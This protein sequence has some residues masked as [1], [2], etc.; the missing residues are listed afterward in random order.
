VGFDQEGLPTGMQL[1][2]PAF[3]E[4]ILFKTAHAYQQATDWHTRTPLL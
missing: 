4:E 1:M 3:R 2:G